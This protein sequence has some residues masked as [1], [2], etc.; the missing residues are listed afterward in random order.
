MV[1]IAA[2]EVDDTE[3][4]RED[5][6]QAHDHSA[7]HADDC[8]RHSRHDSGET[9]P[10]RNEDFRSRLGR[11]SRG[12]EADGLDESVEIV[13]DALVRLALDRLQAWPCGPRNISSVA[14]ICRSTETIG[15]PERRSATLSEGI[16]SSTAI[17]FAPAAVSLSA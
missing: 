4:V 1:D 17:A 12:F 11:R 2:G 10:A 9:H 8:N 7:D 5:A 3:P 16:A 6:W 15:W 13:D 14:V